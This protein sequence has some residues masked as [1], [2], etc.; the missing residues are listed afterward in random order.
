MNEEEYK[1]QL[2]EAQSQEVP[3]I[4]N[5]TAVDNVVDTVNQTADNWLTA[6]VPGWEHTQTAVGS[7]L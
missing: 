5:K 4:I 1:K 7:F 6:P 3:E 2:E